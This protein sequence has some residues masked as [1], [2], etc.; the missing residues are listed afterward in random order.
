[1]NFSGRRD[2]QLEGRNAGFGKG[3][4]MSG[5]KD[6]CLDCVVLFALPSFCLICA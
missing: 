2:D 5:Q 4:K 3:K 6:A 1:M